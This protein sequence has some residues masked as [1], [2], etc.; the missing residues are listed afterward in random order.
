MERGFVNIKKLIVNMSLLGALGIVSAV[1]AGETVEVTI[2]KV[3]GCTSKPAPGGAYVS[4]SYNV[5]FGNVR[6]PCDSQIVKTEV[7]HIP[8]QAPPASQV[9]VTT[10]TT[11]TTPAPAPAPVCYQPAPVVQ[12]VQPATVE[13]IVEPIPVVTVP[14]IQYI[15]PTTYVAPT[16]YDPY[17]IEYYPP[18]WSYSFGFNGHHGYYDG[19]QSGIRN[20]PPTRNI[21]VPQGWH[22]SHGSHYSGRHSGNHGS[23]HS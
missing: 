22:G 15:A 7:V 2:Y 12:I 4:S 3:G 1:K 16:Y 9:A 14:P 5:D 19:R 10:T 8:W 6:R 13:Y 17:Y 21:N 23:N 20:F 11:V 18:T